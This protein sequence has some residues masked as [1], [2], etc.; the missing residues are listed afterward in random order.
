MKSNL[1]KIVVILVISS[2]FACQPKSGKFDIKFTKNGLQFKS[3]Y[4]LL[5]GDTLKTDQIPLNTKIKMYLKGVEG[6]TLVDSVV[7]IGCSMLVTEEKSGKEVMNEPDL[8]K[9]YEESGV[10]PELVKEQIY[11]SLSVGAPMEAGKKYIWKTRIWDKKGKGELISET[12]IKVIA[13]D[14]KKQD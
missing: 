13:K 9:A 1:F 7:Y 14:K 6:L 12:T 4:A 2:L 11:L 5:E 10:D 8:F 3:W